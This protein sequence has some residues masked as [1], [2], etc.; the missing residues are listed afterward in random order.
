MKYFVEFTE[1]KTVNYCYYIDADSK[2]EAF[3]RAQAQYF[4]FGKADVEQCLFSQTAGHEIT[5]EV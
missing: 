2:E 1:E 3:V 5:E 4:D